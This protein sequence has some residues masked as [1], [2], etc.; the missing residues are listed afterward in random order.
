MRLMD[1][2]LIIFSVVIYR[3]SCKKVYPTLKVNIQYFLSTKPSNIYKHNSLRIHWGLSTILKTSKQSAWSNFFWYWKGIYIYIYIYI[4]VYIFWKFIQYTIHW[5][6]IQMFKKFPSD[7]INVTK[8]ALFFLSQ[9]PNH[10]V[11]FLIR[12]SYPSLRKK[13]VSRKL[14]E[15]FSIF[16]FV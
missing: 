14:C 6:K 8:S 7:K 13:L 10:P 11:L 1:Q 5:G 16:E 9:A 12:N 4:Y 2:A 3:V 15:G